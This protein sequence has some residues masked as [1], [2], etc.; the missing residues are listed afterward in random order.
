MKK[1][2]FILISSLLLFSC[3]Q[4]ATQNNLI[5]TELDSLDVVLANLLHTSDS[6][7]DSENQL[8]E[9]Q[10]Q[11]IPKSPAGYE[12]DMNKCRISLA[13]NKRFKVDVN[14]YRSKISLLKHNVSEHYSIESMQLYGDWKKEKDSVFLHINLAIGN[15]KFNTNCYL[16]VR[17]HETL[18][19]VIV[20]NWTDVVLH[21]F[22]RK[23]KIGYPYIA[24]KNVVLK[25]V[26]YEENHGK[27]PF[28]SWRKATEDDLKNYTAEELQIMRSEIL[29][30]VGYKFS[31]PFLD[32]YFGQ[33]NWYRRFLYNRCKDDVMLFLT[34]IE[35][36]NIE[37][38]TK[39]E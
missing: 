26:E 35:K 16:Y 11:L 15:K 13:E 24:R 3:R 9:K 33:F 27:Y 32:D 39:H 18:D 23:D 6:L 30:R 22:G 20:F 7:T 37:F 12:V 14:L 10:K 34:D 17:W 36:Y 2:I 28:L 29:A 31:E 5:N 19:T 38:I 8:L 21:S 25:E 1:N 4:P